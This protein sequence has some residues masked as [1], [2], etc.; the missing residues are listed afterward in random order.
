M[1]RSQL[2]NIKKKTGNLYW[3][4]KYWKERRKGAADDVDVTIEEPARDPGEA[5][6]EAVEPFFPV[7]WYSFNRVRRWSRG[8]DSSDTENIMMA[9]FGE[10]D[11]WQQLEFRAV[12][13]LVER[14][15]LYY[16]YNSGH[17][18]IEMLADAD[19]V[20]EGF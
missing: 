13:S 8:T 11:G 2:K 12:K 6:L 18:I 5:W 3:K 10:Q 7:N 16:E 14:N 15:G 4:R 1:K 17:T 9:T 19:I 20:V